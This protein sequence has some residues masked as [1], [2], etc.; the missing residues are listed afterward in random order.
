M[1]R[2][3]QMKYEALSPWMMKVSPE[4]LVTMVP[5]GPYLSD[6]ANTMAGDTAVF[7]SYE[8][9]TLGVWNK[10]LFSSAR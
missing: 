5:D 8:T 1:S 3:A 7:I 6:Q 4:G 10:V 2:E 9:G